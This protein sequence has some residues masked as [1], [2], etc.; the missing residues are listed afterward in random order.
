LA[1]SL[2]HEG[3]CNP[4]LARVMIIKDMAKYAFHILLCQHCESPECIVACPTEAMVI[5]E[6]GVVAIVDEACIR[7]EAGFSQLL[8]EYYSTRGWD[9]ES[10]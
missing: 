9:L 10:G 3:E 8:D 5:D 2:Y 1:C 6:R 4:G 7:D